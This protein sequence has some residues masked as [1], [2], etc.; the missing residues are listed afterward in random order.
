MST[1]DFAK[2]LAEAKAQYKHYGQLVLQFI[3]DLYSLYEARYYGKYSVSDDIL[4]LDKAIQQAE[5]TPRQ[6]DAIR[7]ISE[8][9]EQSEVAELTGISQQMVSKH[10][11]AAIR[12]IAEVYERWDEELEEELR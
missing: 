2:E 10:F 8:G 4:V 11:H 1:K 6:T 12:K 5:L 7:L 9:Y 3:G